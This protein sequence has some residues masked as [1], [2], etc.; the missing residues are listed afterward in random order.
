MGSES[1]AGACEDLGE[2]RE[3]G[4]VVGINA[5]G[6]VVG[7]PDKEPFFERGREGG[8]DALGVGEWWHGWMMEGFG[9]GRQWNGSETELKA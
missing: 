5:S 9:N 2:E 1:V 8:V 3:Q 6:G 7:E 4:E